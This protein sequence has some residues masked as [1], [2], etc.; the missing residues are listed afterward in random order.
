[1]QLAQINLRRSFFSMA[2][3][4]LILA[5]GLSYPFLLALADNYNL[6][7]PR[8]A[9][10]APYNLWLVVI[11]FSVT[12][13]YF[14]LKAFRFYLHSRRHITELEKIRKSFGVPPAHE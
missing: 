5:F 12:G 9:I 13:A 3:G 1:V 6:L 8:V 11:L 10:F 14:T 7:K 4:G 2:F